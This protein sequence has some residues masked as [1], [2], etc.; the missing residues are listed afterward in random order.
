MLAILDDNAQFPAYAPLRSSAYVR[1]LRSQLPQRTAPNPPRPAAAHQHSRRRQY[2]TNNI[3][4]LVLQPENQTNTTVTPLIYKLAEGLFPEQLQLL[5]NSKPKSTNPRQ[6]E[7]RRRKKLLEL[8]RQTKQATG[9]PFFP[10]NH[11][12]DGSFWGGMVRDGVEY[13]VSMSHRV[14]SSKDSPKIDR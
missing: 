1:Q 8:L 11:Q 10:A 7:I 2:S 14:A 4:L 9:E 5:A 6:E 13:K 3:D 12:L